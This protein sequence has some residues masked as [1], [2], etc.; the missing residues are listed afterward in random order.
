MHGRSR[1]ET[2]KR[3]ALPCAGRITAPQGALAGQRL[4]HTRAQPQQ[5]QNPKAARPAPQPGAAVTGPQPKGGP[6]RAG[7]RGRHSPVR[8]KFFAKL[9]FKKAEESGKKAEKKG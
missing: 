8:M 9:S 6:R 4:P 3:P 7:M 5:G 1:G 2:Q